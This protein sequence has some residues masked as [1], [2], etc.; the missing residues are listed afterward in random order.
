MF[1]ILR[2]ARTMKC[3]SMPMMRLYAQILNQLVQVSQASTLGKNALAKTKTTATVKLAWIDKEKSLSGSGVLKSQVVY[4]ALVQ[5][6]KTNATKSRTIQKQFPCALLWQKIGINNIPQR[7]FATS[8]RPRKYQQ[9]TGLKV[10]TWL[11]N[12]KTA[13]KKNTTAETRD[14]CLSLIQ[15]AKYQRRRTFQR[16]VHGH[17]GTNVKKAIHYTDYVVDMA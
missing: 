17:P 11:H 5:E 12:L 4:P 2:C 10:R 9:S 8:T 14:E 6:K 15:N 7:I 16:E 13:K 3:Q 1:I